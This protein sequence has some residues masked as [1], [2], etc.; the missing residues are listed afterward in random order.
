MSAS[1]S[2]SKARHWLDEAW[3]FITD[4][5]YTFYVILGVLAVFSSFIVLIDRKSETLPTL[6]ISVIAAGFSFSTYIY[7]REKFRLD[8][9]DRRWEIYEKTLE[10]CSVVLQHATLVPNERNQET[11]SRGLMAAQESFRGIGHHKTRAL[12]GPDIH[13][14][15]D[16]MNKSYAWLSSGFSPTDPGYAE[17]KNKHVMF[18]VDTAN[19]LPDL[20][21][22]Y[23]Y[24]GDYVRRVKSD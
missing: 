2:P 24:F 1:N 19:A 11:I 14:V 16:K 13:G 9:L 7:S 3:S 23:V 17:N 12:F 10:F 8:L 15:F 20:F 6:W 4:R 22:P 5:G 18:I 21:R